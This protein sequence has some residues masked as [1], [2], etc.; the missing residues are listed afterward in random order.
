[1]W[2]RNIAG[3]RNRRD[4]DCVFDCLRELLEDAFEEDNCNRDRKCCCRNNDDV[5]GER[6]RRDC[7]CVFDC[8]GELLEGRDEEERNRCNRCC[9]R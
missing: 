3:E 8:L 1:M 6:N 4:C 2:N 7:D 9:F 5:R